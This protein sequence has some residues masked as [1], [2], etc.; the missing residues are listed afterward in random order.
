MTNPANEHLPD[1]NAREFATLVPLVVLAFWIGIYPA[2]LF[3]A[4]PVTGLVRRSMHAVNPGVRLQFAC[5]QGRQQREHGAG[6]RAVDE[7]AAIFDQARS[8]FIFVFPE[9]M[10]V[11][12]GLAIL[13][14]DFLLTQA[15]KSW[16][17]Y[18]ALVG[19]LFSGGFALPDSARRPRERSACV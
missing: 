16:N 3:R 1:L 14:T 15:Q 13:L 8:D 18:T 11:F 6:A 5:Q 10:L 12:F 17:A 2:P 19:V 9:A 4:H 7:L